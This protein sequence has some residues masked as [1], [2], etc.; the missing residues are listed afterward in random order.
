MKSVKA[1]LMGA[2]GAVGQTYVQMLEGHPYIELVELSASDR[3]KGKAYA[4]AVEGRWYASAEIPE[5]ARDMEVQGEEP[6]FK[7]RLVFST[8]KGNRVGEIE[9]NMRAK[10]YCLVCNTGSHRMDPD[11][12]VYLPGVNDSHLRVIPAQKGRYGGFMVTKPNCTTAGA[13]VICRC[14]DHEFGLEAVHLVTMQGLSGAGMPGES[15]ME[16]VDGLKTHIEGEREKMI[17]E[18]PKILGEYNG[19]ELV[20]HPVE[21]GVM[22]NRVPV[23]HGHTECMFA[24]L[25]KN[26]SRDSLM[27]ALSESL[28][29]ERHP[30]LYMSPEE[31]IIVRD[32]PLKPRFDRE[33]GRG[34]TVVVGDIYQDTVWGYC[35][36]FISHNLGL[37]AAGGSI[38]AA[39][40]LNERG[41]LE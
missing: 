22:C 3:S 11:V 7:S 16:M 10:G 19:A 6:E 5:Y 24:K 30:G 31:P 40:I 12:P 20:P 34:M 8:S 4:E 38:L 14:L 9:S 39:E 26:P 21:V 2:T 29:I 35:L 32:R 28:G 33:E 41:Y 23:L 1:A 18:L 13:A 36:N 25:K 15:A 37:G 17:R 27:Q